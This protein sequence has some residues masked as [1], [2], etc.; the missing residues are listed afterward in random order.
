[1][2]RR[3]GGAERIGDLIDP[4]LRGLGVRGQVREEQLRAVFADIV[5][6]AVSTMCVAQRLERGA[7]VVATTNTA[8]SHQLQL[9][10]QR[11]IQALNLR[12]GADVVRRLR[13]IP[14]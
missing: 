3:D 4:A 11:V 6:P 1:L 10:S 14:L 7:L 5:G 9:D 12:L 2:S 13:F 8:L